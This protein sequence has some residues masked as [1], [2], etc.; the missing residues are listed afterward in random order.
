MILDGK[1]TAA[2]I[3]QELKKETASVVGK[4]GRKPG[5]AVLLVGENPASESYVKSKQ[6]NAKE[7]GYNSI[8]R[9]ENESISEDKVLEIVSD[10]NEDDSID[11]ILVQLPLPKHIDEQKIINS[12]DPDKDVDGFSP[13]SMG[14]LV[15]GLKGFQPC[16][17]AGI[18][19]LLRRYDIDTEG[20]H[21]VVVGRSNIVGKPIANMLLQKGNPG[22]STVTLCH[23]RTQDLSFYTKQADILVAAI[24]SPEAIDADMIKDGAVV[25][26]VG[27]NRVE[28]DSRE[29]G[30]RLTGDVDLVNSKE[31]LKAYTPVPGG[32][33]PMTIA[34]LLKNTLESAKSKI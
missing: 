26:D 9:R 25:I 18:I 16:T 13:I 34:M 3:R 6:K 30:Y 31:K 2:D 21:V 27:I 17:P 19:E 7:I 20:K 4:L 10:W 5:L 15:L 8:L 32:V 33:G 28:D 14:R 29:R 11:G 22:N 24:G 23:S 1:K 12:I